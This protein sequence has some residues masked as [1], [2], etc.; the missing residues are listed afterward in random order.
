MEW[1]FFLCMVER[2][3]EREEVGKEELLVLTQLL[4]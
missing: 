1:V 2:G 4:P 3:R